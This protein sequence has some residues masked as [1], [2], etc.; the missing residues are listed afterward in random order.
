MFHFAF[1]RKDLQGQRQPKKDRGQAHED[2]TGQKEL[3]L[4][5]FGLGT[6]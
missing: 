6:P 1:K 3:V 5:F 2:Q 4:P